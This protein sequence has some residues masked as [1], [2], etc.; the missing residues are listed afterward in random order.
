MDGTLFGGRNVI[1]REGITSVLSWVLSFFSNV[2][3]PFNGVVRFDGKVLFSFLHLWDWKVDSFFRKLYVLE[4]WNRMEPLMIW[5]QID[6][7]FWRS[8]V[9][10]LR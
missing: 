1:I 9:A 3:I 8:G 4:N 2:F 10:T 6:L 5:K 7:K